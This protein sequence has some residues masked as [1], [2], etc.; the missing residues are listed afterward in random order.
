MF[1]ATSSISQ[2][3]SSISQ[4]WDHFSGSNEASRVSH[5]QRLIVCGSIVRKTRHRNLAHVRNSFVRGWEI[6]D[7]IWEIEDVAFWK[8][9]SLQFFTICRLA[10][11][12]AADLGIGYLNM[13]ILLRFETTTW[14]FR[15]P[16]TEYTPSENEE[17]AQNSSKS[18]KTVDFALAADFCEPQFSV[19]ST[20]SP[21]CCLISITYP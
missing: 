20:D 21:G 11:R 14:G 13:I 18:A 9:A 10:K 16:L 5:A 6:E 15:H 3:A 7:V 4:I 19:S 2:M 8:L 1:E 17:D 12:N